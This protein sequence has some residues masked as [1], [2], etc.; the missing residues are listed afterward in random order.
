MEQSLILKG[1]GGGGGRKCDCTCGTKSKL[2]NVQLLNFIEI[3]LIYFHFLFTI[4][5]GT[6]HLFQNSNQ[7]QAEK[8]DKWL[9]C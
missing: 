8:T 4:M 3:V 2:E 9:W 7:L 1:V 5:Y 6:I